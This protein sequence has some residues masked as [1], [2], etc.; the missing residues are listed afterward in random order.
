MPKKHKL[1]F[2]QNGSVN[3]VHPSLSSNKSSTPSSPPSSSTVNE[4]L[5]RLRREQASAESK[6]KQRDLALGLNQ[7]SVPPSLGNI[8]GVPESAPPV[9]TAGARQRTR[10]RTP[11]P[12]PPRSWL[13]SNHGSCPSLTNQSSRRFGEQ[14]C[15]SRPRPNR[16]DDFL[17]T[18]GAQT[19]DQRSL[20]H[21]VLRAI[22][23]SWLSI[24][25]DGLQYLSECPSYVRTALVSY[26]SF[27][28]P[29]EG[30]SPRAME[31]L[32]HDSE[33]ID[34]L[35]LTALAG[36]SVSLKSVNKIV[37]RKV[38]PRETHDDDLESWDAGGSPT[39][40]LSGLSLTPTIAI[41]KL[42]LGQ[43]PPTV[44][45][46]DLMTLTSNLPTLT[47]LSLAHWPFPT[48]TPGLTNAST[49]SPSGQT[50]SASGSTLY[51]TLD[52]DFTE[53]RALLRQFSR[54]TY[55]LRYLDLT[56]CEWTRAL[57]PN[58]EVRLPR[59][60]LHP[61]GE[62]EDQWT[63]G[64]PTINSGPDWL[65]SWKGISLLRLAQSEVPESLPLV[66][67]FDF[68]SSHPA[69][70]PSMD[71]SFVRRDVLTYLTEHHSS[72]SVSTKRRPMQGAGRGSVGQGL[73]LEWR[74]AESRNK[75]CT[76]CDQLIGS[77]E[78][79]VGKKC[80]VCEAWHSHAKKL[81]DAW[82]EKEVQLR[83][84]A[85]SIKAIRKAGNGPGLA[86][87]LGWMTM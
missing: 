47:H 15:V 79:M 71:A 63:S 67:G 83:D 36:W 37:S 31:A 40:S 86:I 58:Q 23:R 75:T 25:D 48:K 81:A 29:E 44:L 84:I 56:G 38:A 22:A 82:I 16:H 80:N 8:L 46:N 51:S 9:P 21:H 34:C 53:A 74:P 73:G 55:C 52:G 61:R 69:R 60:P 54:N 66:T 76:A 10:F 13:N 43:P 50:F 59:N 3:Y 12:A 87:D 1:T 85:R 33:D 68:S 27:Y 14:K 19:I 20:I 7:H 65:G 64:P 41:T 17:H 28:G 77:L 42:S 11:G 62:N 57:L 2:N 72:G 35:D 78:G 18:V 4:R 49:S 45:W 30:L 5:Q 6:Q 39:G 32:L 24:D 70:G 26:I